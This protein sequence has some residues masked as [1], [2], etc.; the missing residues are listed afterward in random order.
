M[1]N[2]FENNEQPAGNHIDTEGKE[3][4]TFPPLA[5]GYHYDL[6]KMNDG[7]VMLSVEKD[8]IDP[9][10]EQQKFNRRYHGTI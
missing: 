5:D 1:R 6:A 9:E 3:Y 4:W 10:T 7:S 2:L 8:D